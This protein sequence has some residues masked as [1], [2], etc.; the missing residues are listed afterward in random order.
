MLSPAW[1]QEFEGKWFCG[2][3]CFNLE[4]THYRFEGVLLLFD[5]L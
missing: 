1:Y 2:F 5:L 4:V 3:F